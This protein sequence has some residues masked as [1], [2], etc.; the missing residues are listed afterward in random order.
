MQK[1]IDICP[2]FKSGEIFMKKFFGKVKNIFKEYV[3][4]FSAV[5][6][7]LCILAF[8]I[9]MICLA[10]EGFADW[11]NQNIGAF[12]RMCLA[13]LT[14]YLPFSLA[15]T[16]VIGM[17]V[18]LFV[19]IYI[20]IKAF[21]KSDKAAT[22]CVVGLFSVLTAMYTIFVM[23]YGMGYHGSSLADKLDL[24]QKAVSADELKSTA[25]WLAS[26]INPLLDDID[27]S[28]GGESCMPYTLDELNS[29]LND[30]YKVA[31]EKY[32]F[33]QN[34]HSNIKYIA[35][36]EPMTYTHISGVYS[37]YTGEANLNINFPDYTLPFTAAHELAHQ[38]GIAPENEANFVAFLVCLESDDSY[39][40]YSAYLN[41]Y[42]YVTNALY[43]AD[44]EKYYDVLSNVDL[45]VR[46]EMVAYSEFFSKYKK[47]VASKV[48]D[49]VND[50]YLKVQ[51]QSAGSASYGM[52][53][54]L[55]VAYYNKNVSLVN[56]Y[57]YEK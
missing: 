20:S 10:S 46:K 57:L 38:R 16:I 22:R 36:S 21:R 51:G 13:Y 6:F 8:I 50:T 5:F 40:K 19:M 18:L 25:D 29:K 54:D 23:G 55:A 30:A 27:F 43:S 41:M 26:E 37:Y 24:E 42:E 4:K 48:S 12:V 7:A 11:Y 2:R 47:S 17:P 39:I 35:L 33:I 3:P 45:R 32:D 9:H 53:V 56:Y 1:N 28:V 44:S 14:G 34:L 49:A 52:V 15:E 31:C